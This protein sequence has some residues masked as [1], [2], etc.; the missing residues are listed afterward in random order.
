MQGQMRTVGGWANT[1]EETSSAG[2]A[3]RVSPRKLLCSA[4]TQGPGREGVGKTRRKKG[5]V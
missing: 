5:P 4:A 3:Q 2:V 1:G